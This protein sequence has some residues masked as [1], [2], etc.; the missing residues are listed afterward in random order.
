MVCRSAWDLSASLQGEGK[1]RQTDPSTLNSLLPN[2][3]KIE[4]DGYIRRRTSVRSNDSGAPGSQDSHA[5]FA[6]AGAAPG[7]T[8]S[9]AR[10]NSTREGSVAG[11]AAADSPRH[12]GDGLDH[13]YKPGMPIGLLAALGS[14]SRKSSRILSFA[15]VSSC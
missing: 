3:I 4:Q 10:S 13:E 7:R 8:G 9:F 14:S 11:I 5:G 15:K 1:R 2:L 6:A 12:I